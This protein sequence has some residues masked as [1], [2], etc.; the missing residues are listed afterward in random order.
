MSRTTS[1]TITPA[2]PVIP[3]TPI[4]ANTPSKSKKGKQSVDVTPATGVSVKPQLQQPETPTKTVNKAT[5]AKSQTSNEL[6]VKKSKEDASGQKKQKQKSEANKASTQ[7]T[8]VKEPTKGKTTGRKN[9]LTNDDSPQKRTPKA[10]KDE[11]KDDVAPVVTPAPATKRQPPSKLDITAATKASESEQSPAIST[12]KAEAQPKNS[13]TLPQSS[14]T[15]VPPSPA[16]VAT[17]SPIKRAVAPRTLRVVPTPKT[18]VPPPVPAASVPSLPHIPTVGKLR[19]RQASIASVNAPG[20]PA[21]EMISDTASVTSASYSRASSPPPIGGKVGTAPVRKKTK[22]QAKKDRQERKRQIE[23]EM[24]GEENKSDVEVVQAPIIGRKKKAKKPS[25]NPKPSASSTKS[26]PVSPKPVTIEDEQ[27][28]VPTAAPKQDQSAKTSARA[29]PDLEHTSEQKSQRDISAQTIMSDLQRTGELLASTL[30]FFKPLSSSLTHSSRTVPAAHLASPPDLKIHF[31][32]A[33][34]EALAKKKPV[35]LNGQDGRPDSRTLITPNGK[36]FWGL[37]EELEEK[38]LELEKQIDELKGHARFHPRKPSLHPY[39]MDGLNQTPSKDVL[40]AIAT[41]LKEA[42]KK[43]GNNGTQQMPKLDPAS[44]LMGPSTHQ[45]QEAQQ[46]APPPPQQTPA[47]AGAYLNQF[48]L[49]KTDNPPPNQPRPEMAAVGGAP[50]AGTANISVNAGKFAKAAK[51]VV[52]GGAVGSTEIDGMGMMAADLLGGVFVQGLEALVGAGLGLQSPPE[53]GLDGNETI[54]LGRDGGGAAFAVRNL[55]NVMENSNGMSG[56]GAYDG[57][58]GGRG[59]GS[60][61]SMEEAE[62]AMHAAKKEHDVLEKKLATLMKKN[63]KMFC[64]TAKA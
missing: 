13:R 56:F 7:E 4:R 12:N 20:T 22:S 61:M 23:E 58:V 35:R 24:A 10:V 36:F 64:G 51:A 52:E 43:L 17:G 54:A 33:D 37:S 53:F 29:T 57:G 39:N 27:S 9:T 46:P 49:P 40:P 30:E 59:R 32:E 16:A 11:A 48:V 63:K 31:S 50:G 44:N 19:S 62:R 38:A 1:S 21:S 2:V 28:D 34:L 15:S 26:V 47:D 3:V 8:V 42:G 5:A 25:S 45:P 60:V 55:L 6:G 18:E 14:A 41:A